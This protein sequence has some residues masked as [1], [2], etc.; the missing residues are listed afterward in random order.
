MYSMKWV[1]PFGCFL[2]W[3]FR[4]QPLVLIELLGTGGFKGGIVE[5]SVSLSV[6]K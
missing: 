1:V 3:R 5:G 4:F 6:A 2:A